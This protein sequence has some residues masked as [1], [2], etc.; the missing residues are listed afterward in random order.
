MEKENDQAAAKQ[1]SYVPSP[2][3][4]HPVFV[5]ESHADGT[6]NYGD[7]KLAKEKYGAID[8]FCV[9]RH[10]NS[11]AIPTDFDTV[12]GE[13]TDIVKDF[14]AYARSHNELTF[15]VCRIRCEHSVI[16]EEEVI[17]LFKDTFDLPYIHLPDEWSDEL[18]YL[19]GYDDYEVCPVRTAEDFCHGVLD[20]RS[21]FFLC[22]KFRSEIGYG[23][24][25][26]LPQVRIRYVA[27]RNK[28]GYAHFGNYFF[29]ADNGLYVWHNEDEYEEDHAPGIAEDYFG[30]D[31]KGRGYTCR[32]IF[33]GI[34]TGYDDSEGK[35]MFTGDIVQVKNPNGSEMGIL[36]LS[37]A[38]SDSGEGFYGFPLDN[39]SLT[40]GMCKE[41]GYH[42]KRIGT[43]FYQLDPCKE[44][45]PIWEKA[46][47]YNNTLRHDEEEQ[48][49]RTMAR[50]TP[51]F[52]KEVWKYLGLEILGVE[53]FDWNK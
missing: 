8:G 5:Y 22:R 50:Y 9:G 43:I 40:L 23:F 12:K 52:D 53:P 51:N 14:T 28:F 44:P 34:D 19:K 47:R 45:E 35:R 37:S 42:L 31:C 6:H 24:C 48:N 29:W 3:P 25:K 11:Y 16:N 39:H 32:H 46:I 30:H 10:G 27:G 21:L 1:V 33:A 17:P 7:A 38:V 18:L 41:D 2:A 4:P 49:V 36:C 26:R 20:E 13:F 15:I